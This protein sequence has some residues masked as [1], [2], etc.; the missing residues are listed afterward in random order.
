MNKEFLR[1]ASLLLDD[2]L[3]QAIGQI[4]ANIGPY[5]TKYTSVLDEKEEI[6]KNLL[7][8]FTKAVEDPER[9]KVLDYLKEEIFYIAQ[10]VIKEREMSST[11]SLYYSQLRFRI[12]V[13]D[14]SINKTLQLISSS[15]TR[16]DYDRSVNELFYNI[17]IS[18][19]ITDIESDLL[20]DSDEYIKLVA[21]SAITLGLQF[22]W[23]ISK[24]LFLLKALSKPMTESVK[25]R[26]WVGI[27]IIFSQYP[28]LIK[29]HAHKLEPY[30]DAVWD[31]GNTRPDDVRIVVKKLFGA[32]QTEKISEKMQNELIEGLKNITPDINKM[33]GAGEIIDLSME[34]GS[35]P[36]WIKAIEDAGLDSAI[37]EFSELQQQGA[38]VMYTSFMNLKGS[39]F[40]REL[41]NWFLPFDRNHSRV[42]ATLQTDHA[43]ENIDLMTGQLCDSDCYSF[44]LTLEMM[45]Y[46]MRSQ[47]IESLNANIGAM[48]DQLK[49]MS[50]A[51]V[52]GG[53]YKHAVKNYIESLYRFY[54]LFDRK[55]EFDDIFE[56]SL[57]PDLPLMRDILGSGDFK[58]Q[59]ADMLM[60]QN[61]FAEAA[62]L[63]EELTGLEHDNSQ[64]F[65]KLGWAYQKVCRWQ[66]A[67]AAYDRADII[68][69]NNYWIT[70]QRA[71]CCHHLGRIEEAIE[72]YEQCKLL[73]PKNKN[74]LLR[75][76]S[77]RMALNQWDKALNSYYEYELTV[78]ESLRTQ[79]PIAWC[80]VMSG[81]YE[82]AMEYYLKIIKNEENK[83]RAPDYL[84][85][86]HTALLLNRIDQ[87]YNFYK[88]SVAEYQ[89]GLDEF[90]E[91]FDED[92]DSLVKRG[93]LSSVINLMRDA[94][95]AG[96]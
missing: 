72:L 83:N 33:R 22:H 66:D 35:D 59:I 4:R 94:V 95:I 68:T 38:D 7:L 78:E 9:A 81:Q 63:L 23:D 90:L 26:L 73:N 2:R 64:Y 24:V 46:S 27:S 60:S 34:P 3:E 92:K 76:A 61:R 20:M 45:P 16:Q 67:L 10:Q 25:A 80:L 36:Q 58:E 82:R 57:T 88:L 21:I 51:G 30:W 89:G 86:G 14:N 8:Y 31:S 17:W 96:V 19:Q 87:A 40:F 50:E 18:E 44:I 49:Q 43:N 56:Q 12:G 65:Q 11:G 42:L 6:Y 37:R 32:R 5:G 70:R 54:K 79:R 15:S 1:I 85:A 39:S 75:I 77:C 13:T 84:N 62:L 53:N 91:N 48:K 74:L 71:E 47:A 52:P 69:G 28:D 41:P 29:L 93:I 55:N